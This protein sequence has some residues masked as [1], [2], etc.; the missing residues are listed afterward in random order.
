[1]FMQTKSSLLWAG[2]RLLGVL[3]CTTALTLNISLA[4]DT[5]T[6]PKKPVNVNTASLKTLETLPGVTPDVAHK[7][8]SGR[9]YANM[10]ELQKASGLSKTKLKA[11]K[12]DVTFGSSASTT[13]DTSAKAGK[14]ATSST[15]DSEETST[16]TSHKSSTASQESTTSTRTTPAPAPAA[17]PPTGSTSGKLAPGETV[18]INTASLDELDALPGIG[19]TK[20]QAIVDYRNQ[21]GRFQ[22]IEDIQNVKGIKQGEFSKIK[23]LIRTQ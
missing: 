21:H 13:K 3:L 22:S 9:P 12:D 1:M 15:A 10:T 17:P 2:Q 4:Q 19:P 23:D 16:S 18:N 8:V 6:K 11:I 7:I 5:T 14:K 20:A